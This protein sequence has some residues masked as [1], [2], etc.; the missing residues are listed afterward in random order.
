MQVVQLI[1]VG[2]VGE[3]RGAVVRL[4][5][6]ADSIGVIGKVEDENIVLLRVRS[7]EARQRLHCLDARQNFVH[8]H[9]V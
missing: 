7:I 3:D 2:F 5:R 4:K 8:V 9:R 6:L 1:G